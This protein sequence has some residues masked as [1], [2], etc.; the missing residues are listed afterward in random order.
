M[1]KH[2]EYSDS[3]SI[4]PAHEENQD[5]ILAD[6]E[7]MI[8][9]VAD[10][11]GGY[12]GG[13]TA[14]SLAIEILRKEAGEISNEDQIRSCFEKIHK[15]MLA[16]AR[17]LD[18][19]FMGT[20]L[21]A[22]KILEEKVLLANVGD[23]P[24]FLIQGGK[25]IAFYYDDSQRSTDPSNMWSLKRYAGFGPDSL[26]AHSRTMTPKKGDILLLCSDGISD[27]ILG[28]HRNLDRL[29]DLVTRNHSAKKLVEEAMRLNYKRDD[30]SAILLFF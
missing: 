14:S 1:I 25:A 29:A 6:E 21:A 4:S 17:E 13:K 20:T 26:H 24:I 8:F 10:G 7:A 3:N 16:K 18:S 9:A 11:V 15:A 30:M 22:A 28:S 2:D 19:P 12:E 23:S 5:S 27:N